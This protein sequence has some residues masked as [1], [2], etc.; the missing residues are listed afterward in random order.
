VALCPSYRRHRTGGPRQGNDSS[1]QRCHLSI[2]TITGGALEYKRPASGLELGGSTTTSRPP[3]GGLAWTRTPLTW[4]GGKLRLGWLGWRCWSL[5]KGGPKKIHHPVSGEEAKNRHMY[6]TSSPWPRGG[7][8]KE[9]A[10]TINRAVLIQ[11]KK[12]GGRKG[13]ERRA[14]CRKTPTGAGGRANLGHGV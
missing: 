10:A 1:K 6:W 12:G 7:K 11:K 3:L 4:H 2:G 9:R 5:S 13:A 8:Q 14:I